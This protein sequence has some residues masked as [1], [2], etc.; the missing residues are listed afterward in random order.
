MLAGGIILGSAG[1]APLA[2]GATTYTVTGL[3]TLPGGSSSVAFGV[4]DSGLVVGQSDTGVT[5]H[6]FSYTPAGGMVDLGTLPDGTGTVSA[7]YAVSNTGM[8]VGASDT[9]P[10]SVAVCGDSHAFS[11][12]TAGGML[13]LGVLPN[14][15]TSRALGGQRPGAGGRRKQRPASGNARRLWP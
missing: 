13:D 7:A 10:H 9:L 3:G 1:M 4:N 14:A 5:T 2:A 11:Y 15:P 12:T 8:I 6:A